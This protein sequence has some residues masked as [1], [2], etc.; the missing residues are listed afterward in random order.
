VEM[1]CTF[2]VIDNGTKMSIFEGI[3]YGNFFIEYDMI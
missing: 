1:V 3:N 2:N